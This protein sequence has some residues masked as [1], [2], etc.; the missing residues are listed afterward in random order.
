MIQGYVGEEGYLEVLRE[1]NDEILSKGFSVKDRT[2]VGTQ[3]VFC[4]QIRFDLNESFPLFT[5]KQVFLRGIFEELMWFLR[6]Q[7]NIKHLLEKGVHIWTEWCYKEYIETEFAEAFA[8]G[9]CYASPTMQR[10]EE[11]ILEDAEFAAK[12]GNIGKGYGHQ[13]RN[14][15]GEHPTWWNASDKE[16]FDQIEWLI[17]EI[18]TNPTS[19]RLIVSGWNPKEVGEV[20]L[21]PCHTLFQF[22]VKDGKLSCTLFQRSADMLLGVPFNIASYAMLTHFIAKACGLE[23]G[24][25]VWSGTDCHVYSNQMDGLMEILNNRYTL[26]PPQIKIK[27]GVDLYDYQWADIEIVGYEHLGKVEMPVAV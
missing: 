2:G 11:M 7:T 16:G 27:D 23:V 20:V 13:W 5:H 10:F 25:F 8:N 21:P 4:R 26:Q 1:I 14:F 22:F 24:E 15:G 18:K 6:G 19:R 17:N 9:W 3:N 12:W